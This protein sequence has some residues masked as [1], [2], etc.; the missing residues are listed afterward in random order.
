LVRSQLHL[1]RILINIP[2]PPRTLEAYGAVP[3][4]FRPP[5]NLNGEDIQTIHGMK[6]GGRVHFLMGV[7]EQER[8]ILERTHAFYISFP[9]DFVPVFSIRMADVAHQSSEDPLEDLSITDIKDLHND[10][11]FGIEI[12]SRL[13][14]IQSEQKQLLIINNEKLIIESGDYILHDLLSGTSWIS[15]QSI[16][17]LMIPV[18]G[19]HTEENFPELQDDNSGK[20]E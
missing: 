10:L 13:R 19:N 17:E 15:P 16:T 5:L 11:R 9:E 14:A 12:N 8:E 6:V 20:E 2:I 18:E 7:E 1:E 4:T 3:V